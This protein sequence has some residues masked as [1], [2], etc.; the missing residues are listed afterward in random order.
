MSISYPLVYLVSRLFLI[1]RLHFKYGKLNTFE[2][3]VYC[4]LNFG[5]ET[6]SVFV[7]SIIITMYEI[8]IITNY[9]ATNACQTNCLDSTAFINSIIYIYMIIIIIMVWMTNIFSKVIKDDFH[10]I[11]ISA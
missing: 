10:E 2:K 6:L 8:P 4:Y 11:L 9:I 7:M 5:F 1:L 3:L